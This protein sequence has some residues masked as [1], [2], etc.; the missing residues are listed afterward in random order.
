MA[1]KDND[2]KIVKNE[3]VNLEILVGFSDKYTGANYKV[4]DIVSFEKAR[5]DELLADNRKLVCKK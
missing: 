4:G 2:E 5:A 3:N 1:K